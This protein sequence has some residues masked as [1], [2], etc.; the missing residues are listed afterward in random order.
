MITGNLSG[1]NSCVTRDWLAGHPYIQHAFISVGACWLNLQEALWRISR[2]TAIADQRFVDPDDIDYA[3]R[4]ATAQLNIRAKPWVWG[5][6]PTPT[7]LPPPIWLH[8]ITNAALS[9]P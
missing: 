1:H 6:P 3:T 8:A 7:T 4:I 2:Q 9:F 5:H